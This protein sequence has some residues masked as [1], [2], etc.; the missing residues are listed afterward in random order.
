MKEG[1]LGEKR[2]LGEMEKYKKE[3]AKTKTNGMLQK[4]Y[5]KD[6]GRGGIKGVLRK[7]G[8]P[9]KDHGDVEKM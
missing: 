7:G 9:R 8:V 5:R 2:A 6:Q 4:G 1:R 3:D